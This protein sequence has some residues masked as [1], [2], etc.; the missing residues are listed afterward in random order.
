MLDVPVQYNAIPQCMVLY[1]TRRYLTQRK[2]YFHRVKVA[3][4]TEKSLGNR[5]LP[6]RDFTGRSTFVDDARILGLVMCH[7]RDALQ[8]NLE[9]TAANR[10]NHS[11]Y[12]QT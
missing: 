8:L 9:C 1:N 10:E 4:F 3:A 12:F 11:S 5:K 7:D 2:F 6:D